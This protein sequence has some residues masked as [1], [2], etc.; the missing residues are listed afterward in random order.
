MRQN[1]T[2]SAFIGRV[3]HQ[4]PAAALA[5]A[6]IA[7]CLAS[8]MRAFVVCPGSRSA[9]L[10]IVLAELERQSEVRLTVRVDERSA[11]FVA[12]GMAKATQ[13]PVAVVCTS[14]SA[15]TNLFPAVVEASYAGV[16]LVCLTA[17]RPPSL[18]NR[19]GNQT[20]DQ[21]GLFGHHVRYSCDLTTELES[22]SSRQWSHHIGRALDRARGGTSRS[23]AGP[24]Q[25]NLGLGGPL[26]P[27]RSD[28]II[29]PA[30]RSVLEEAPEPHQDRVSSQAVREPINF[31]L[32]DLGITEV[33]LQAA[34]VAGD[35]PTV[36]VADHIA[37]L[38]DAT[39]WPVLAEPNSNLWASP[40]VL[41]AAGLIPQ[42]D[43]SASG[44][45][46]FAVPS[47]VVTVGRW[48]LHRSVN[49]LVRR[50]RHHVAVHIAGCDRPDPLGT[51]Q[52]IWAAVPRPPVADPIVAWEGPDPEWFELWATQGERVHEA[53]DRLM[54]EAP[55]AGLHAARACWESLTSTDD[56]FV[57][58]SRSVRDLGTVARYRPDPPW[59]VG[60][61]G[62]SGID[63]LIS[64]AW[65][66][67]QATGRRTVA[68]L[69]DLA[70]LH[71]LGGL[72]GPSGESEPRLTIVV[73]NNHGGGIFADL[74]QG[75]DHLNAYFERVFAT[76]M[77]ADIPGVT[78][79]LNIPTDVV[80]TE[81]QLREALHDDSLGL[82]VI[83]ANLADRQRERA[84]H[85]AI[86]GELAGRR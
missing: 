35:V 4:E 54:A 9:P 76:P 15:P 71:D 40:Q 70:T 16:P 60:N 52:G 65:G 67:A 5:D 32:A 26:V 64:T 81:A 20:I 25:I 43:A 2:V 28:P 55:F 12:L 6:V 46:G 56:L 30:V 53:V 42:L 45:A 61:R 19:G 80:A 47:L 8:G 49:D 62:T 14:G 83:V 7:G 11:A 50:A 82:R 77:A 27:A 3:E 63:G 72:I 78:A 13:A 1:D 85:A 24:V 23:A 73:S 34:I 79:A 69:G 66:H 10:A 84:L 21:V 59:V 57:A 18:R 74:E 31:L 36:Q 33:P 44:L 58:A 39:G 29:G 48:G 86:T 68:L 75:A 17:D 38:A 22:G 37:E 51:A 41:G